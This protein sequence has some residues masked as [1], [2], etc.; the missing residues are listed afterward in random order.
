MKVVYRVT[1]YDDR[2]SGDMIAAAIRAAAP[3]SAVNVADVLLEDRPDLDGPGKVRREGPDT[4]RAARLAAVPRSGSQRRR[5]LVFLLSRAERGATDE[6]IET[7]CGLGGHTPRR[8]EL[9]E[10]GWAIDSGERR[11]TTHGS[12]ATVWVATEKSV[13]W[14]KS[15]ART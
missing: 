4:A 2:V 1:V 8:L 14:L 11:L 6:E 9:V 10:G 13:A 3:G 7:N 15:S 12:K 5:V